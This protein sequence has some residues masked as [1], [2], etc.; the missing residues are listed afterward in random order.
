MRH[1]RLF[2]LLALAVTA[3]PAFA[4]SDND[5]ILARKYL[6]CAAFYVAGSTTVSKPEVKQELEDR[7]N[8]SLYSAELLMEKD[9]PLVKKEFSAAQ[10]KF[11]TELDSAEV[12]A[13]P[14]GF[15]KFMGEY[16]NDL[17]ASN[18]VTRPEKPVT[19]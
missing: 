19:Q 4:A 12:K 18:P 1:P 11:F 14:R 6:R 2:A 15:L 10:E 9:R 8:R 17:R 7:A 16:C 5:V 3:V 13:D